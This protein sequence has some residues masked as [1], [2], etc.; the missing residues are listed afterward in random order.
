MAEPLVCQMSEW[1]VSDM[2]GSEPRLMGCV[3]GHPKGKNGLVVT[4]VITAVDCRRVTT[5][6]GTV[7]ELVG[8]P[9]HH[10]HFHLRE[11]RLK[12]DPANPVPGFERAPA[13]AAVRF[14]HG[15]FQFVWWGGDG[16]WG[17]AP[18]PA[19]GP[20]RGRI[21]RW[22]LG[23]GPIEVRAWAPREVASG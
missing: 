14:P 15:R 3:S 22:R 6:S 21:Y 17:S 13:P 4:A 20:N 19:D 9:S 8:E 18:Y 11:H 16:W 1:S 10:Q 2:L 5:E 12:Y 23:L 7:Y